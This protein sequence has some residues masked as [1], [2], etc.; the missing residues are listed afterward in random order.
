MDPATEVGLKQSDRPQIAG[1]GISNAN[2]VVFLKPEMTKLDL[3]RYYEAMADR[4]LP[5]LAD[6]PCSLLRLPEG[7]EGERFFQKHAGKGFPTSVRHVDIDNE[8]YIR[9]TDAAGL[10][11][12]V[13]MGTVEFHPWGARSGRL[14]RPERMVFDLDPDEGVGFATTRRG[15]LEVREVL[16][17]VGLASW[18]MLSG[19]KGIHVI[20]P[21]HRTVGWDTVRTLSQLIATLMSDRAPDRFT[22]TMSKAKRRGRIFIDWLRNE[23]GATA[24]APFSVRARPGAPVAVPVTWDELPRLRRAD[25]FGMKA[26]L[27]RNWPDLPKPST[28]SSAILDRLIQ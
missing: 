15:A 26:T 22:A 12:A 11:G 3:A 27:D 1:I 19:G 13:Q 2:R 21:L 10:V 20:V 9:I 28:I 6:R 25:A 17:S 14:D 4:I 8:P 16:E 5:T 24:I 23:R 7:L 18:P